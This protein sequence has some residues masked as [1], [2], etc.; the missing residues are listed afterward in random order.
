MP[1]PPSAPTP[2]PAD[3]REAR[4]IDIPEWET[5]GLRLTHR[6]LRRHL[7]VLGETG[8]GKTRS[9]LMP[10]MR[11]VLC[12]RQN[13]VRKAPSALIIDPKDGELAGFLARHV[14]R[15]RFRYV[16]PGARDWVVPFFLL[17]ADG[18]PPHPQRLMDA[19]VSSSRE[20]LS[21]GLRSAGFWID[22]A[23]R[24][25]GGFLAADHWLH[26][27][28]GAEAVRTSWVTLLEGGSSTPTPLSSR[29]LLTPP[30]P[31]ALWDRG[32]YLDL[33]QWAA[34]RS[35]GEPESLV[36]WADH[37]ARLGCPHGLLDGT[38]RLANVARETLGG[39]VLT[40]Q[41]MVAPL[42]MAHTE[43]HLWTN[44]FL[45]PPARRAIDAT[46]LMDRGVVVVYAPPEPSSGALVLARALKRNFFRAALRTRDRSRPFLYL[47]DEAH[48]IITADPESSE[49]T[50]LDRARAFGVSCVLGTQSVSSLRYALETLGGGPSESALQVLLANIGS[51]VYMR[52]TDPATQT[53]LRS[54]IPSH[55]TDPGLPHIVDVRP[56]ISL[57]TGEGYW[58]GSTGEWGR[59]RVQLDV[60]VSTT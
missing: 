20:G 51:Q 23:S 8:S 48:R 28:A 15:K 50:F 47:A 25:L 54:L 33:L 26:E 3:P 18:R 38:A 19:L 29:A 30:D 49:S 37:Y 32:G 59:G 17:A 22:S 44:P 11:A 24:L 58:L 43:G 2:F 31:G 13:Y 60:P 42:T 39:I 34:S 46:A 7:L 35:L 5:M 12:T 52:S 9:I 6:D 16:A 14:P 53:R 4:M 55:P 1:R 57:S 45:R 56:V 36:R 21:R 10:L 41:N 40:A 27:R